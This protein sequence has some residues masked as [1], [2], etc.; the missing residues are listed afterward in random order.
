MPTGLGAGKIS[1]VQQRVA[2]H[3]KTRGLDL[4][5]QLAPM[6]SDAHLYPV[7]GEFADAD[8]GALQMGAELQLQA[9][10]L[11]QELAVG[12]KHLPQVL[13]VAGAG[14]AGLGGAGRFGG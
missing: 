5:E 4:L 11:G 1:L 2:G 3:M 8:L 6:P 14:G 13:G 12:L 7:V 9:A 10:A